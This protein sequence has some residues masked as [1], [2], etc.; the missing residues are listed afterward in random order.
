MSTQP[1][2]CHQLCQHGRATRSRRGTLPLTEPAR[3]MHRA[4]R[5]P[6]QQTQSRCMRSGLLTHT[7]L[8]MTQTVVVAHRQLLQRTTEQRSLFQPRVLRAPATRSL[9]GTQLQTGLAQRMR[10]MDPHSLLRHLHWPTPMSRCMRSGPSSITRSRMTRIVEV[11]RHHHKL[12]TT[13]RPS[14][15]RPPFLLARV[16]PSV[17][18]IR[19]LMV[20]EL[21]LPVVRR[22]RFWEQQR[23]MRNGL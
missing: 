7:A 17:V 12:L 19:P 1:Q 16:T 21:R 22:T 10:G 23:C 8:S 18:G 3:N 4:Q 14:R 15:F 9:V 20:L 5:S 6:C 13:T 2:Q 11:V